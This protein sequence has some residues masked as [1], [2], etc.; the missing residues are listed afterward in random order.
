MHTMNA[1]LSLVINA[2]FDGYW[3]VQ[4]A[5]D[6]LLDC[7]LAGLLTAS[8]NCCIL[9]SMGIWMHSPQLSIL[10]QLRQDVSLLIWFAA[11][12]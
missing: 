12:L 3:V 8:T 11:T 1:H 9:R 4:H 7:L 5:Q 10:S 6:S 2:H